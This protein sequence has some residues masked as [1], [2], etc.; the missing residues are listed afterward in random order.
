MPID[1]KSLKR[2]AKAQLHLAWPGVAGV[3]L[4]YLLL[5]VALSQVLEFITSNPIG[6]FTAMA[7]A[8]AVEGDPLAVLMAWMNGGG[9]GTLLTVFLSILLLLFGMTLS[10]SYQAYT[11]RRADGGRGRMND[12]LFGF[13]YVGQII[14]MNVVLFFFQ[15]GWNMMAGV[16]AAI[17]GA[18]AMWMIN[19]L[20]GGGQ[21]AIVAG[22]VAFYV[23][24][25]V[26]GMAVGGYLTS[27]YALAPWIL[28]DQPEL[29]AMEAI[30][31]SVQTLRGRLWEA[32]SLSLSFAGWWIFYLLVILGIA[33]VGLSGMLPA[34]QGGQIDPAQVGLAGGLALGVVVPLF[35]MAFQLF[36]LPYHS[37]V[38]ALYYRARLPRQVEAYPQ[39][40]RP[41]PF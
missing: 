39:D 24:A 13:N 6:T 18:V 1:R 37:G 12:L 36:F 5:A 32:F 27:R 30:R 11:L 19:L 3:T 38:Y 16:P 10:I 21:V 29:G 17:V 26:G 23:I 20:G 22:V 40:D 25:L 14:L 31:R 2:E 4:V 7:R 33:G 28:S 34:F 41:E 35:T 15:L 9:E 8:A